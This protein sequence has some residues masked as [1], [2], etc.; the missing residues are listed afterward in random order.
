MKSLS[1][2]CHISYGILLWTIANGKHPYSCKC[3][4]FC[5]PIIFHSVVFPF[6]PFRFTINYSIKSMFFINADAD[7]W[8]VASRIPMG[9]RPCCKE[10]EQM[11]VDGLKKLIP[12]M[13]ECWHGSPNQR[14]TFISKYL[15]LL[16]VSLKCF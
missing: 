1:L 3:S 5:C 4:L 10:I 15:F 11:K 2:S 7:N 14:P 8:F 13:K 12:L 9:H 16:S 6:L